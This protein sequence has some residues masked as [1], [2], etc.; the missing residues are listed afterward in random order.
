M[1]LKCIGKSV[2][3]EFDTKSKSH[4][5]KARFRQLKVPLAHDMVTLTHLR[6]FLKPR[7]TL[8]IALRKFTQVDHF[9]PKITQALS[10]E[11]MK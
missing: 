10:V 11:Q 6:T 2:L 3:R 8:N 5:V 9:H 7:L 4:T 1:S